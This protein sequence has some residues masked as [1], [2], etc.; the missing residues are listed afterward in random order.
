MK[1]F[2]QG[3]DGTGFGVAPAGRIGL[4]PPGI[5][6]PCLL[7]PLSLRQGCR[8]QAENKR[9]E[10]GSSMSLKQ[11]PSPSFS[12]PAGST[13]CRAEGLGQQVQAAGRM[14]RSRRALRAFGRGLGVPGTSL[15]SA[16]SPRLGFW[17]AVPA[18]AAQQGSAQRRAAGLDMSE[19]LSALA[20]AQSGSA[21]CDGAD[22]SH[23][24]A[25]APSPGFNA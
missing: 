19:E 9:N 2:C 10:K 4:S 25:G 12:V 15:I 11:G 20:G 3:Q 17:L 5:A 16:Q 13:P 18:G 23:A 1:S 6:H 21:R 8:G 14:R 22:L 24:L 7:P